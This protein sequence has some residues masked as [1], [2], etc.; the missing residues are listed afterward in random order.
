MER[1]GIIHR[2]PTHLSLSERVYISGSLC[3]SHAYYLLAVPLSMLAAS[4][5]SVS[6]GFP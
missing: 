5:D 3:M 2:R 1:G 4:S 6:S